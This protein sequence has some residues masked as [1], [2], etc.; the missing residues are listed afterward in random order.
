VP[1]V[2]QP[3]GWCLTPGGNAYGLS[4]LILTYGATPLTRW[5]GGILT[6]LQG[7]GTA[8]AIKVINAINTATAAN[9]AA[10]NFSPTEAAELFTALWHPNAILLQDTAGVVDSLA[11]ALYTVVKADLPFVE[12]LAAQAAANAQANAIHVATEL[13]GTESYYRIAG[14]LQTLETA[15][16]NA[17]AQVQALQQW[18]TQGLEAE[19]GYS[20]GLAQTILQY[21]DQEAT[22][23]TTELVNL[24]TYT[25]EQITLT[26][27]QA[28]NDAADTA[29]EAVAAT[30]TSV[31]TTLKPV[32][33]GTAESINT[34]TTMLTAEHPED[35]TTVTSVSPITPPDVATAIL[36]L[37]QAVH[38]LAKTATTCALPECTAKN[39]LGKQA[40]NIAGLLGDGAMLAFLTYIITEPQAAASETW[41]VARDIVSPIYDVVSEVVPT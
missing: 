20:Q 11:A 23:L 6:T 3:G 10:G 26:R 19:G 39:R 37:T 13:V 18:A 8:N 7:G 29:N 22:T 41:D 40:N 16:A 5:L 24:E 28:A 38:T 2:T 1:I 31:Q 14:D 33:A 21:V 15:E 25:R 30:N 34:A 4:S 12:L 17:A 35:D 32:W 27:Q 9:T 36:G